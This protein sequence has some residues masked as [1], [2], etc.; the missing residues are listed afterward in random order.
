MSD[1]FFRGTGN[2]DR[3]ESPDTFWFLTGVYALLAGGFII[4]AAVSIVRAL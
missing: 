3:E 4:A 1:T 2:G